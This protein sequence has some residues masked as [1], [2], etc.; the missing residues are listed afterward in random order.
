MRLSVIALFLLTGVRSFAAESDPSIADLV[1][2]LSSDSYQD[3]EEA[4]RMLWEMG[5][6]TIQALREARESDDPETSMRA[7]QIL[8]KVELAITPDT[9][10][11]ILALIEAYRTAQQKQKMDLLNGLKR[12]KAW[13]QVLKLYSMEPADV[14]IQMAP[15]MRGVAISGAREAISQNDFDTAIRLLELSSAE[16]S[17]LMALASIYRTTGRIDEELANLRP[18]GDVRPGVWKTTLL[19]AKGDLVGAAEA[20]ESSKQLRLA[21]ALRVL[22]GDPLP[23]LRQNGLGDRRQQ[24]NDAYIAIALKRW[25]GEK[26]NEAD[27]EP[28]L[29]GL[30]SRDESE[31]AQAMGSLVALG[32]LAEAEEIQAKENPRLAFEYYLS[33]ERLPEALEVF[34]LDPANPDYVTW[35]ASRFTKMNGGE[36]DEEDENAEQASELRQ[37]AAF[38]GRRG[39]H[40]QLTAAF[41]EPLARLAV[42]SENQFLDFLQSLFN[43]RTGAPRFAMEEAIL[44]AGEDEGRWEEI[45]TIALGEDDSVREWRDWM[46]EIK[47]EMERS[48]EFEAALALF[49][50]SDDTKGLRNEWLDLAWEKVD[51]ADERIRKDLIRR[52]LNLSINQ[53]DAENALK[54]YDLLAPSGVWNSID[55]YLSAAGR[56]KEAAEILG[57][58]GNNATSSSP[59][60][61]AYLA[62]N[63]RR[64]GMEKEAALH[65]EWAE[66]LALGFSP[67]C[68]RIGAYYAYGGDEERAAKWFSR[69][70]IQ[71]D[72]TND[73][74]VSALVSY[75]A[76]KLREGDWTV[77]A[78][79]YEALVQI[80]A[81][82][83][84]VRGEISDFIKARLSA[85]LAKALAVLPDDRPRAI[86]LLD[87]MHEVLM[88]DGVLADEFFPLVR[89]AGLVSELE[90]WFA[91]SWEKISA[92]IE[93]YPESDNTRNTAAWFASR[94]RLKLDEAEQH[95][96]AALARN[97]DQAAYL[98]TMAEVQFAR[99]K[100]KQALE[101]SRRS[102]GNAPFDD[103]IRSQYYRFESGKIPD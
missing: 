93:K 69:A 91:E 66:K 20:A 41:H 52:I 81:S 11:D 82:Q 8:A 100:R 102:V 1:T 25:A 64:A 51:A 59:E 103:M 24:A 101:W 68:A 87:S 62:V 65:D 5:E 21:S 33:Q 39:E 14:R 30:Q 49:R 19:R 99:G 63:Y 61:H 95:L 79:C 13:F 40:E 70:A 34:G 85:D 58:A 97:P 77:A 89:E 80:F 16:G 2:D 31:R 86:S 6:D 15:A 67:S 42:E 57:N 78:S 76:T 75:S 54:A 53:Q 71:A 12:K 37:L 7:A 98:D 94:A 29:E 10:P 83:E 74:F 60:I 22:S 26:V 72:P 36:D 9:P 23:W 90:T 18:P 46:K 92:V 45:F 84:Y 43:S 55:R 48:E 50:I 38:L 32:R 47:P 56:W 35:A 96:Q 88:T 17:D 73:E 44:W 4:T 27:F 3:R 28:L